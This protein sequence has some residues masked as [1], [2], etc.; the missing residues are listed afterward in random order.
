MN[1]T[2]SCFNSQPN[3]TVYSKNEDNFIIIPRS[4]FSMGSGPNV[5]QHLYLE[6]DSVAD[7]NFSDQ[8]MRPQLNIKINGKPDT[9]AF[10]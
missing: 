5:N 8:E 3:C 4:N 1:I 10:F 2:Y 7:D 9:S 6:V